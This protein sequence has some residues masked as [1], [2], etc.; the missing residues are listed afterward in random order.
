MAKGLLMADDRSSLEQRIKQKLTDAAMLRR[1]SANQ[2]L[3]RMEQVDH[4]SHQFNEVACV[5]S[6]LINLPI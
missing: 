3:Q 4:R 5:T 6:P 2:M 1:L